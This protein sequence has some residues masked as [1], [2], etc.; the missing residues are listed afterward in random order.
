METMDVTL[1]ATPPLAPPLFD[2][3]A[4]SIPC[5]ETGFFGYGLVRLSVPGYAVALPASATACPVSI[6]TLGPWV[7]VR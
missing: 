5:R 7:L 4:D 6:L 3:G 2:R 1:C